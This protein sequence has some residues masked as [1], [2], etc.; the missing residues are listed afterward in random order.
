M[1][2]TIDRNWIEVIGAIWMPATTCAQRIDLTA[3]D[4]KNI[5]EPT[6]ENVEQWLDTHTGDFHSI[7]DFRAV[8]GEMDLPWSNEESEFTYH[9]CMYPESA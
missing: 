7:T 3:S 4:I 2:F 8:I 9:D 5:G 6:R 1:K